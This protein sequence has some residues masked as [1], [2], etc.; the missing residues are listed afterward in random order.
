[1]AEARSTIALLDAPCSSHLIS[2]LDLA[3]A[4]TL[5]LAT[6]KRRQRDTARAML[7]ALSPQVRALKVPASPSLPLSS[8]PCLV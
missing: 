7:A 2:M 3:G 5:E 1:M 6:W 8:S 4:L